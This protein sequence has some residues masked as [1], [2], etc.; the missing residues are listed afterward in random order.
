MS[1]LRRLAVSV[2]ALCILLLLWES[3]SRTG[4]MNARLA[5]PPSAIPRALF[6]EILQGYWFSAVL[7]SL[8]HYAIGLF[9]GSALGVTFGT[10]VALS[11]G[12]ERA[13]A[14]ITRVL[15]PIPP[16]AWIPFAIIW[17]GISETAAAFI[18]AIG[19]FWLNYFTSLSAIQTV[20][21]DLIELA[22]AFGHGRLWARLT[23]VMLPAA[24]PGIVGG[25]RAGLGQGWMTVVAAEL[26]GI[27]G[28]GN[29]MMEAS[30]LLATDI[31]VLYMLTIALLYGVSDY[32]FVRVSDRMLAW[33]R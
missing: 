8:T 1:R 20:D 21:R 5:P 14:G 28:I 31:V 16:L 7:A 6:S 15:R 17:F 13:L 23:K 32:V 4:I 22:R 12:L 11:P 3:L 18:I 25:L 9:I 24:S 29:R 33:S 10:A 27:S 19:V 2:A 26:F 30:S